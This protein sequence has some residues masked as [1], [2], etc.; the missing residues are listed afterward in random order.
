MTF[1]FS[2]NNNIFIFGF[3]KLIQI[4]SENREHGQYSMIH[5][6]SLKLKDLYFFFHSLRIFQEFFDTLRD[7][8]YRYLAHF[9]WTKKYRIYYI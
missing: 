9:P 8:A 6:W 2:I 3:T 1:H 5:P 4:F 7:I